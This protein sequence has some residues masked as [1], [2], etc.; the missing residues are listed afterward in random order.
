MDDCNRLEASRSTENLAT[1]EEATCAVAACT[2]EEPG[3]SVG[4]AQRFF[5][6]AVVQDPSSESSEVGT[7]QS[8]GMAVSHLQEHLAPPRNERRTLS[9][10]RPFHRAVEPPEREG[11]GYWTELVSLKQNAARQK[12]IWGLLVSST[13]AFTTCLTCSRQN[14]SLFLSRPR[15]SAGRRRC[16][17]PR[18]WTSDSSLFLTFMSTASGSRTAVMVCF[19]GCRSVSIC[20]ASLTETRLDTF[21]GP[22]VYTDRKFKKSGGGT[23]ADVVIANRSSNKR[24]ETS[25]RANHTLGRE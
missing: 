13:A 8:G 3:H 20:M 5:S 22:C 24:G 7:Q 1:P 2:A 19:L 6:V 21:P 9:G 4:S 14:R 18:S 25:G 16:S 11:P 10:L 15:C 23:D 17:D 12:S